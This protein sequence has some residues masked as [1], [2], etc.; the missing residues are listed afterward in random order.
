MT[1]AIEEESA[2]AQIYGLIAALYFAPPGADLLTQL[3]EATAGVDGILAEPWQAM[4]DAVRRTDGAEIACEYDELFG[5]VAEPAVALYGSRHIAGFH[6]EKPLARLRADLAALGL[7]RVEH[8]AESED[9]IAFLC[10][11]MRHLIDGEAPLA[12]QARFFRAHIQPWADRMCEAIEHRPEARF[13]VP[14]ARLTQAF[15]GLE[16]QGFDLQ[17]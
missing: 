8:I 10:E 11:V 14:V 12:E 17:E 3:R 7:A 6:N 4:L 1:T 5:G 2:R 9:H 13:Y 16:A 15:I